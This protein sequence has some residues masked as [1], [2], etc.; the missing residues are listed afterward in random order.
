MGHVHIFDYYE[1]ALRTI[2][3]EGLPAYTRRV[4]RPYLAVVRG[5]FDAK[6]VTYTERLVQGLLRS[7]PSAG[8]NRRMETGKKDN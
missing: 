5:H 3:R 2:A 4:T 8:E 7:G 6:T 1:H